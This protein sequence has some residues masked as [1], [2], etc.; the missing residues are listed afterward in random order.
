MDYRFFFAS[1]VILLLYSCNQQDQQEH[2]EFPYHEDYRVLKVTLEETKTSLF[3]I[4]EKIEIV[5]LETNNESL[6]KQ[7]SKVRHYANYFYVL[8]NTQGALFFF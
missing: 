5:P 2:Q 6:I 4:F 1:M 7:I 3:D 8:D